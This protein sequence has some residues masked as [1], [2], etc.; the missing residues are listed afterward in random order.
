MERERSRRV[1]VVRDGAVHAA[2]TRWRERAAKAAKVA[3][4]KSGDRGLAAMPAPI[5]LGRAE[6]VP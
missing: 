6:N 2:E 5:Y 3:V 4:L 1:Q